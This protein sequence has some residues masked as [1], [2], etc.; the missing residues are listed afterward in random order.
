M[1]HRAMWAKSRMSQE[2][3][4]V[5]RKHGPE[6]LM[7]FLQEGMDNARYASLNNLRF[8]WFNNFSGFWA[9]GWSLVV[10][11]GTEVI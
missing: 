1:P 6:H 5:R 8:R 9:L 10:V 3:E 2:A 4:G 11:A 7:A